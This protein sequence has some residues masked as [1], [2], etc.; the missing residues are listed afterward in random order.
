MNLL[1]LRPC[2]LIDME[3]WTVLVLPSL[4]GSGLEA[5]VLMELILL[6]WPR[7]SLNTRDEKIFELN[8]TFEVIILFG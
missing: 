2:P 7:A 4:F 6:S 3:E 5:D 1:K 8:K